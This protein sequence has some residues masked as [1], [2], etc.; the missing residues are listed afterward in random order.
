MLIFPTVAPNR[1]GSLMERILLMVT[2]KSR[3]FQCGNFIHETHIL[4]CSTK[5]LESPQLDGDLNPTLFL[6]WPFLPRSLSQV[7]S[8]FRQSLLIGLRTHRSQPDSS[9]SF[10]QGVHGASERYQ[11]PAQPPTSTLW[12]EMHLQGQEGSFSLSRVSLKSRC[13]CLLPLPLRVP[14]GL[15]RFNEV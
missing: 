7:C 1:I 10:Q 8:W 13:L 14:I 9:C 5:L 4:I 2:I 6:A 15:S 12:I 3:D 11:A